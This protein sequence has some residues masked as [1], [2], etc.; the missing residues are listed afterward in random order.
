MLDFSC[1]IHELGTTGVTQIYDDTVLYLTLSRIKTYQRTYLWQRWGKTGKGSLPHC[2]RNKSPKKLLQFTQYRLQAQRVLGN[3]FMSCD[4]FTIEAKGMQTKPTRFGQN[5][6][7][8][9]CDLKLW[10]NIPILFFHMAQPFAS[11]EVFFLVFSLVHPFFFQ[12][13]PAQD[14]EV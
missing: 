10:N 14:G 3:R 7:S 8:V 2:L 9:N 1:D 11:Y 13:S 5:N 12:A 6:E 4:A